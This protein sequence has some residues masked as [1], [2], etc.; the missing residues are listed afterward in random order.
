MFFNL[1]TTEQILSFIQNNGLENKIHYN[2]G[3]WKNNP[4]KKNPV[5]V[6]SYEFESGNKKG[7]IAFFYNKKSNKWN[8][9][10]FHLSKNMEYK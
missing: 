4:D 10:S 7:Y 2:T 8:I 9:K 6:D 3:L 1:R 5:M